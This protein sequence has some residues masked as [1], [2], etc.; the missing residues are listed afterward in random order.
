M[1][2]VSEHECQG[3]LTQKQTLGAGSAL[4]LRDLGLLEDG[5]ELG[6]ALRSDAVALETVRKG[7]GEDDEKA[8]MSAGADTKGNA[9]EAVQVPK[10]PTRATA[11]SNC[12]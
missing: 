11:G 6:D 10:Q 2:I 3:A 8:S 1:G 12:P 7:R 4:E 5:R 9:R